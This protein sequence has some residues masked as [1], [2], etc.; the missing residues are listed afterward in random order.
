MDLQR[1]AACIALSFIAGCTAPTTNPQQEL[2]K[3]KSYTIE[4]C[5]S[6]FSPEDVIDTENGWK[7]W[8]VPRD[9]SPTFNFKIS[10]V[11]PSSASHKPHTHAEE[12]IFY[13]LEGTAEFTLNGKTRTVGPKSTMF[14]PSNIPH[15]IR[16]VGDTPLTYAVIK[17]SYPGHN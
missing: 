14:C 11:G 15:G 5:I 1:I 6:E 10:H 3:D 13:I 9:L 2:A 16:N 12:E 8:H 7:Y 4:N 17:A